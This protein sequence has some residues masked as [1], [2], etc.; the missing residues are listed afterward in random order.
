MYLVQ[1]EE[2]SLGSSLVSSTRKTTCSQLHLYRGQTLT[3]F[4]ALL[5]KFGT[6]SK[7]KSIFHQTSHRDLQQC[8]RP[9]ACAGKWGG[10]SWSERSEQS[11]LYSILLHHAAEHRN[12]LLSWDS[13]LF[14]FFMHVY[15]LHWS[16][17]PYMVM[18]WIYVCYTLHWSWLLYMVMRWI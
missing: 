6:C 13:C 11:Y 16:W 4:L 12:R 5:I 18:R 1:A 8:P 17:I 2:I 3:S 14:N 15:T 9:T 7:W 10:G